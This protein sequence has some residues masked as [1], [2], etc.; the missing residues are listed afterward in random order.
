MH[1]SFLDVLLPKIIT[2]IIEDA[3]GFGGKDGVFLRKDVDL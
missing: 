2:G 1:K 3:L